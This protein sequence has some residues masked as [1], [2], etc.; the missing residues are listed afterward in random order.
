MDIRL[1]HIQNLFLAELQFRLAV[2][3]RLAVTMDVQP[4]D[5]PTQWIH[6]RHSVEYK[7]IALRKDQAGIAACFLEHSAE[8]LMAVVIKDAIKA[9][10]PDPYNHTNPNIRGAYQIARLIRNAFTH[11]P[12]APVWSIDTG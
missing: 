4:L 6:D 2:A 3:V 5:M 8:Y 12:F 9:V 1:Q 11:A 7:E 10:E